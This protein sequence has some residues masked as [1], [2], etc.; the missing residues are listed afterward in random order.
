MTE[1]AELE[2]PAPAARV[3]SASQRALGLLRREAVLAPLGA[4]VL[5]ILLTW[6]SVRHPE[7]TIPQDIYDPLMFA[8]ALSWPGHALFSDASLWQANSFFPESDTFAYSDTL[9]G[10]AP[11]SLF[12]H[13]P[14]A[15]LVRYNAMFVLIAFM[16]FLGGY[17]LA[18]QLGSR[19]QGA[20]VAGTVLAYAPWRLSH[21]GHP[22]VISVGGMAL[23]F[24]ALARGHGYSFRRGF[25]PGEI[26]PGWAAAAW[27]IGA[28]QLT[29]GF[30]VGLPFAY[31]VLLICLAG[32]VGWLVTGRR[33]L[34]RKLLIADGLGAL[35]FAVTGALMAIPY[36]RVA[37]RYPEAKRG[38]EQVKFFSPP[39]KAFFV[40]PPESWFWAPRQVAARAA[41][42]FVPEMTLLPGLAVLLLALAGIAISVWTVKQRLALVAIT[43]VATI[44][45]MGT[46]FFG[47]TYSYL[48]L[49]DHLPGWDALRTPGRLM[50]WVTFG[51]GLL[52]A[53]A[54]TAVI[55]RM[56]A[57][58]SRLQ[59]TND[60][61]EPA[62][63]AGTGRVPAF[64]AAVALVPALLVL[65]EGL[66]NTPHPVVP[67]QPSVMADAQGPMI[68]LPSG[69]FPDMWAMYWS[70]S[71]Y[72]KMMNG[73]SSFNP[74]SLQQAQQAVAGFPD[75]ASV[76]YLHQHG[77]KRVVLVTGMTPG[78]PWENAAN[79][80]VDGLPLTRTVRPDG[81][82]YTLTN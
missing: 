16:A 59:A 56:S 74:V 43:A 1:A 75:A 66:N 26:R 76:E 3:P 13:G 25:Q 33:P 27:A 30:A 22:N 40:A 47:G 29:I 38:I 14:V 73:S 20:V 55:D 39:L 41:I 12:G 72:P 34:P 48:V 23:M 31:V 18:R 2:R 53:G 10:Y 19:W 52:A 54:V 49:L 17:F 35:L 64:V 11:L 21:G 28:W 63:V 82:I 58:L 37:D 46:S 24:A 9:L 69:S 45:A 67:T 60:E 61:A 44:L 68:M 4:F 57:V 80:P 32:G 79:K 15:A 6:P 51:L 71:T 42:P 65:G 8:W 5:A 81:I 62:A 70:T 77:V 78:T 36:Q 7:T 50:I